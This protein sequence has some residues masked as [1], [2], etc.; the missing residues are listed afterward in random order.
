[1]NAS[2]GTTSVLPSLWRRVPFP[3]ITKYNSHWA[4]CAWQGKL[5][6][7]RG[8]RLHS[9]SNGCRFDKSSE[10]GSRPSAS[11]IPLKDAAYFPPRDCHGSSLISLRL[12]FFTTVKSPQKSRSSQRRI[13]NSSVFSASSAVKDFTLRHRNSQS[14]FPS[15]SI[16]PMRLSSQPTCRCR[17]SNRNLLLRRRCGDC[18]RSRNKQNPHCQHC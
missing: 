15:R 7:P 10:A 3:E 14:Q 17:D 12:A 13:Q 11:E 2:P 6:L 4:E 8:T 5:L 16:L 18:R 9:R 1:M